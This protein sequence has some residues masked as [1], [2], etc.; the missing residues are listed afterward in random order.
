MFQMT[1]VTEVVTHTSAKKKHDYMMGH[2]I[3]MKKI[4]TALIA[5]EFFSLQLLKGMV[6]ITPMRLGILVLQQP[7]H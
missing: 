2:H 3:V 5:T 1:L 7:H 6:S 4:T